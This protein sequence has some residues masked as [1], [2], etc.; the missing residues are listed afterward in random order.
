MR[1]G[2]GAAP[3]VFTEHVALPRKIALSRVFAIFAEPVIDD[4]VTFVASGKLGL[5]AP[6]GRPHP[7]RR[8]SQRRTG[9]HML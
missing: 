3:L 6:R 1:G 7:R 4:R 9:G 8:P 2:P 5:P